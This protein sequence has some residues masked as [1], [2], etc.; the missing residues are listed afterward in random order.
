MSIDWS[1][2][3]AVILTGLVLV[4][5]VLAILIVIV[6]ITGRMVHGASMKQ[7]APAP[8]PVSV[9]QASP[10]PAVQSGIEEE[11]VAVIAAAASSYMEA[12]EPG[13][14]FAVTSISR[15]QG[16]RPVWGFAGMQQNTRPF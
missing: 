4:F 6:N 12:T 2:A 13:K 15:S 8:G 11:I 7:T 9:T 5:V 3:G 10:V 16:P 1:L 14:S